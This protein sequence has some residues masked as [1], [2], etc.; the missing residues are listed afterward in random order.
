MMICRYVGEGNDMVLVQ[1]QGSIEHSPQN[2]IE[3]VTAMRTFLFKLGNSFGILIQNVLAKGDGKLFVE[4][5][6]SLK[7]QRT[8]TFYRVK[9][10]QKDL[11]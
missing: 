7:N 3:V 10:F 1:N 4:Q 2:L 9:D 5:I 11:L 8:P 6:R